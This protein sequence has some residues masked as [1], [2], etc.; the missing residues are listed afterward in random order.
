MEERGEQQGTRERGEGAGEGGGERRCNVV[1]YLGI[2][3]ETNT[4]RII[5]HSK[6]LTNHSTR[7]RL[8]FFEVNA[9]VLNTEYT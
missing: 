9:S 8:A 6:Y 4:T 1:N 3:I 5:H 7:I 2:N